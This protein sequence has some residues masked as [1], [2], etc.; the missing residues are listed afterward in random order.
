M[1]AGFPCQD[2]SVLNPSSSTSS[3]RSC[4]ADGTLRTGSVLQGIVHYLQSTGLVG[5]NFC[6]FENVAGLKTK[7]RNADGSTGPSNL[8]HVGHLISTKTDRLLHV[9]ELDPRMFGVPQSRKRLWMT[10]IPRRIFEGLLPEHEGYDTPDSGVLAFDDD[11]TYDPSDYEPAT[12]APKDLYSYSPPDRPPP[13]VRSTPGAKPLVG[14]GTVL[15]PPGEGGPRARAPP[16]PRPQ[17]RPEWAAYVANTP[18]RR[19]PE[20]QHSGLPTPTHSQATT[21]TAVKFSS[22]ASSSSQAPPRGPTER[23][24]LMKQLEIEMERKKLEADYL[25]MQLS[26]VQEHDAGLQG[27]KTPSIPK[28][29]PAAKQAPACIRKPAAPP[30]GRSPP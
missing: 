8:D 18:K 9:W 19:R 3:N 20:Q 28:A 6:L 21:T 4:V 24:L 17:V 7:T 23:E 16:K 11:H 29:A 15:D 27:A 25:A 5:P 14:H 2:C 30:G 12:G 10:A 26:Q 22:A 1:T 13:R